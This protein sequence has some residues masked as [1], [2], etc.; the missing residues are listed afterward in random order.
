V[1]RHTSNRNDGPRWLCTPEANVVIFSL[2]LNLAWEFWQ[3]LFF[4]GLAEGSHWK[5]VL[6]CTQ[7]AFGDA[8]I[9]L[10]AYWVVC[11]AARTRQWV[12]R[13]TRRQILLFVGL[14][15]AVTVLLEVLATRVFDR[16]SYSEAMP[17]VP[18]L[19]VGLLPIAQW[20]LLPPLVLWFVRR[21]LG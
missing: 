6:L 17:V 8:F 20:L 9:L 4:A 12:K 18:G 11:V 1:S 2:L 21:Q 19:G 3:T 7:A 16:W 13:P 10:L 14:G 15:L 5:G